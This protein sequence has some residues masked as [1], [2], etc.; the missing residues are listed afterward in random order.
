MVTLLRGIVCRVQRAGR[1]VEGGAAEEAEG[2]LAGHRAVGID[3]AEIDLVGPDREVGDQ[4]ALPGA[5]AGIAIGKREDIGAAIAGQGIHAGAAG[6]DVV[7]AVAGDH[8]VQGIAGAVEIA[9]AGQRQVLHPAGQRVVDGGQHRVGALVAQFRDH[10]AGIVD[11]IGVVAGAADHRVGAGAAVQKVIAAIAGQRVVAAET[12]QLVVEA[13]SGQ[14]IVARGAGQR[15]RRGRLQ[16]ARCKIA[17]RQR[18]VAGQIDGKVGNH[19]AVDVTLQN[20]DAADRVVDVVERAG[21][22]VECRGGE[23]PEGVDDA[24]GAGIGVDAGEI[25]FVDAGREVGHQ[26]VGAAGGRTVPGRKCK[27]IGAAIA[28]HGVFAGAADEPVA[29]RPAGQGI[30]PGAAGEATA[31]IVGDQRIVA[32]AADRVFDDGVGCDPDIVDEAAHRGERGGVQID[33]LVVGVAGAIE[34]IVAAAVVDRQRRRL[35]VGAEVE[36]RAR[37]IIEAVGRIA[38]ACRRRAVDLLHRI[39]IGHLRRDDVAIGAAVVILLPDIRHD[40][41]LPGIVGVDRVVRITGGAVIGALVA[42]AEGVTDFVDVGLV[43]V[44]VDAGLAVVCAAVLGDPVRADIDVRGIHDARAVVAVVLVGSH[45]AGIR[46]R[47]VCRTAGLNEGQVGDFVPGIEGGLREEFLVRIQPVDVVGDGGGAPVMG[48]RAFV[49]PIAG[50]QPI[51]QLCG[52][53][54]WLSG[55]SS[56]R[57]APGIGVL[58]LRVQIIISRRRYFVAAATFAEILELTQETGLRVIVPRSSK[59]ACSLVPPSNRYSGLFG[60]RMKLEINFKSVN[61]KRR[62]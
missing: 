35:G 23:E 49:L 44:T 30:R 36:Y 7:A 25:D 10:V 28:G 41:V 60:G 61:E 17:F 56:T 19:V 9:A 54:D 51:G 33:G 16:A 26:V 1:A 45:G 47:D 24:R 59:K 13:R 5:R 18:Q 32:A 4:V 15:H 11:D 42:E 29:A 21:D 6:E 22:A 46:E 37:G 58:N 43:A 52:R 53:A 3:A 12:V 2:I 62:N 57:R 20:G 48:D 38:G 50:Q 55:G 34:R 39:D 14:R 31:G 8:V 27:D 40:G